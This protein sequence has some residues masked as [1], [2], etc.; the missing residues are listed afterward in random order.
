MASGSDL[1]PR[2]PCSIRSMAP[3]RAV[4]TS[5]SSNP[6]VHAIREEILT[7]LGLSSMIR[8]RMPLTSNSKLENAL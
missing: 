5:M 1:S 7:S 6:E 2:K 8:V 3:S 4:N